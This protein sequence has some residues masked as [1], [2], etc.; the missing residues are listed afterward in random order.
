LRE[1][2]GMSRKTVVEAGAIILTL[3]ILASPAGAEPAKLADAQ[4]DNITAGAFQ[5][6]SA[7]TPGS[8]LITGSL[9][10]VSITLRSTDNG[11]TYTSVTDQNVVFTAQALYISTSQG[12][13]L[14]VLSNSQN[15]Y[16]DGQFDSV[17][18]MTNVTQTRGVLITMPIG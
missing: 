7:F 9:Q 5:V 6:A 11:I 3:G 10:G 15:Q 14:G 16:W 13:A 17:V 1:E 12:F 8:F 2:N 18:P 4:M